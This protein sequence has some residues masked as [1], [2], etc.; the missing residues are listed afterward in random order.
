MMSE[1]EARAALWVLRADQRGP[2]RTFSQRGG[3]LGF[4]WG[5]VVL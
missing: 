5:G 2:A 4:K 3:V 1:D